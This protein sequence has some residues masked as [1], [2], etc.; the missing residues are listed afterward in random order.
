MT[1]DRLTELKNR[2]AKADQLAK[3]IEQLQSAPH[4]ADA[5][6]LDW[7]LRSDIHRAGCEVLLK[8]KEAELESLLSEPAQQ[9]LTIGQPLVVVPAPM[10]PF[11]PMCESVSAYQPVEPFATVSCDTAT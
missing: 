2:V 10:P 3:E 9:Q 1:N 5:H 8:R 4:E 6:K 7:S 11:I